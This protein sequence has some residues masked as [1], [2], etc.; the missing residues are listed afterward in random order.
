MKVFNLCED[1]I[2]TL[3]DSTCMLLSVTEQFVE[4]TVQDI[5]TKDNPV[6]VT[7]FFY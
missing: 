2:C 3:Q 1:F 5:E 6:N 7:A 4:S